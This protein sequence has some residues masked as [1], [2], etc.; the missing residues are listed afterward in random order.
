[1]LNSK[2]TLNCIKLTLLVSERLDIVC[3]LFS[4]RKGRFW[5]SIEE[6]IRSQVMGAIEF[7]VWRGIIGNL[8]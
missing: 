3:E 1:M 7:R 6:D 8:W 5:N 2:P 4:L